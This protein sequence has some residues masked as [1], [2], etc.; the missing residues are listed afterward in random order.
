[1]RVSK[2]YFNASQM[3]DSNSLANALLSAPAELSP[4]LTFLGGREDKKFPLSMLTEGV[5]NTISIDRDEYEYKVFA[6]I[7][8]SRGLAA[9]VGGGN[10]L[11]KGGNLFHLPFEDRWFINQYVLIS[12]SGLQVRIMGQPVPDGTRWLYPVQLVDFDPELEFPSEDLVAGARFSQMYAP[13]GKDFSRGNASN[14]SAP[15]KVRHKLTTL[16]KSYEMSGRAKNFVMEF[17]MPKQ[18]GGSSKFWMDF[19][20]WQY[21]LQW[22]TESEMYYWYGRQSYNERGI[23]AMKDENGQ[24]VVIGPGLLQQIINKDTYAELTVNKLKNTIRDLFYGMT[25]AQNRQVTLWTGLG[26]KEAFH[27]ALL[28]ESQ[29]GFTI[30]DQGKFVTGSGRSLK[31]TGYFT[32]YEHIDG[33]TVN[34]VSNPLFDHGPV[35]EARLKHPITGLSLESYRMVFV[36]TSNYDGEANL[37]MVNEKGR[38]QLRWAVSGSV[39]PRGFDQSTSRASDIDGAQVNFLKTAGICLKRFDTS[40]D[41]ECV[42]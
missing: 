7:T 20:E 11:G 41:M 37:V 35:A 19:E 6:K 16:R 4:A 29:S 1:M 12:Q 28:A 25:D 10:G 17:E 9:T 5:K 42:L 38:E 3:T 13:V 39:T 14:W 34:V 23:T 36:D 22:K 21:Y 26:G 40:L 24:P 32:T 15:S 8:H 33:H 18:G 31:L 2:Q 30:L 27:N